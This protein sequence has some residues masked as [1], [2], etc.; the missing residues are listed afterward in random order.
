MNGIG[1][2]L[3]ATDLGF[4]CDRATDRALRLARGFDGPA[5][6]A[7]HASMAPGSASDVGKNAADCIFL[8][9]RMMPVVQTVQMARRTQAIVR[10]N[11]MLA[12]GYNMIAVPLAFLG[13]G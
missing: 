4:R 1:A 2:L 6:A 7:G 10:Q 5:L 8:G 3:L 13:F 11:F 12:V 9:D